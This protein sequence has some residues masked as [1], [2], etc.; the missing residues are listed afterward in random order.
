MDI[1]ERD[2]LRGVGLG[3]VA[4]ISAVL[5]AALVIGLGSAVTRPT[6]RSGAIIDAA[7]LDPG[8]TQN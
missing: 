6:P 7:S 3:A 1:E 8:A 2:F 4:L 5:S